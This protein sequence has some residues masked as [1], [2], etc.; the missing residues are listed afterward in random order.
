MQAL[1][2]RVVLLS[3]SPAPCT[4]TLLSHGPQLDFFVQNV[5]RGQDEVCWGAGTSGDSPHSALA[6]WERA[7]RSRSDFSSTTSLA[8]TCFTL[9]ANKLGARIRL[10]L[11]DNDLTS[12][13]RPLH[14]TGEVK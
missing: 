14:V 5:F 10:H 8:L 2:E 11:N 6:F 7:K 4:P 13:G 12:K 1:G 9:V 3:P